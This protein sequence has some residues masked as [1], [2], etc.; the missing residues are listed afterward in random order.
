MASPMFDG[1]ERLLLRYDTG[2]NN[3]AELLLLGWPPR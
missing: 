1:I 3:L 2:Y